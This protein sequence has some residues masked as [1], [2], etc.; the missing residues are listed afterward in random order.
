MIKKLKAWIASAVQDGVAP[1]LAVPEV[2]RHGCPSMTIYKISNG[3]LVHKQNSRHYND[4]SFEVV[5]CK[6]PIEVGQQIINSEVLNKMGIQKDL[7][8]TGETKI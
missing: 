2:V 6:T 1:Q 8:N 5:F 7:F 3:Y 4:V